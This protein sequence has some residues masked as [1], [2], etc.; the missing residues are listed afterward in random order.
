MFLAPLGAIAWPLLRFLVPAI[1][2]KATLYLIAALGLLASHG[3]VA[4]YVWING[5]K[6]RVEAVA[7][8]EANFRDA[9][10]RAKEAN[11]AKVQAAIEAAAHEQPVSHDR[12]E[13]VRQCKQSTTCRERRAR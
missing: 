9:L 7:K 5:Y 8:V 12:V 4:G 13:R 1:P 6:A 2:A 11:D 10:A 3:A